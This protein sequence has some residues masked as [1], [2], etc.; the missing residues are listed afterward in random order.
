MTEILDARQ[1]AGI[2]DPAGMR[3]Y[4]VLG[5]VLARSQSGRLTPGSLFSGCALEI[6]GAALVVLAG[7]VV[8]AAKSCSAH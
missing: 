6:V 7:L 3:F 2:V 8:V 1:R 5:F 4:D